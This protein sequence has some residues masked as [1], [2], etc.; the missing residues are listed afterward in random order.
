MSCLSPFSKLH[1]GVNLALPCGKC[2]NCKAA[3]VSGWAFRISKQAE[4]TDYTHF[5]TIT[6]D[7]IN[8]PRTAN[9]F[10]TL[11]KASI[12]RFFKRLRKIAPSALFKYYAVGEYGT[13]TARPHYHVILLTNS[14]RYSKIDIERQVI[15]AWA[16]DGKPLGFIDIGTL[17]PASTQYTLKYISKPTIIPQ[18]ER[19]DREKEFSLMSKGMGANYLTDSMV[20]W[21]KNDLENRMYIPLKNDHKIKMPRYFKEKIYTKYQRQQVANYFKDPDLYRQ[22]FKNQPKKLQLLKLVEKY[23]SWEEFIQEE[24]IRINLHSKSNNKTRLNEKL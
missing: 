10:R 22:K 1:N 2:T 15:K 18:H 21:H 12:Q 20:K 13:N 6:Y 4:I 17:T 24:K 16:L 11:E 9:N 14:T 19:D 8:I 23:Q 5:L 3:R 7:P